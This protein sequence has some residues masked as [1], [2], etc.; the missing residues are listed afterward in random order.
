MMFRID[1]ELLSVY[2]DADPWLLGAIACCL[3]VLFTIRYLAAPSGN[4]TTCPE[5]D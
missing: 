4:A 5:C 3:L 2:L 1:S